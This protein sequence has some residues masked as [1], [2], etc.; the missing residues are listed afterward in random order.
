MNDPLVSVIIRTPNRLAF[1]EA[2]GSFLLQ[3]TG[4]VR[5]RGGRRRIFRWHRRIASRAGARTGAWGAS[6]GTVRDEPGA[7]GAVGPHVLFNERGQQRRATRPRR[8]FER[9]VWLDLVAGW[10]SLHGTVLW[11]TEFIR[12]LGG[13]NEDITGSEDRELFLRA[14]RRGPAVFVPQAALD[15]RTHISRW[16]S[17]EVR[18]HQGRWRKAYVDGLPPEDGSLDSAAHDAYASSNEGR[19]AYGNLRPREA[20]ASYVRAVQASP[21]IITSP[22][23]RR[24]V[25]IGFAKSLA[26]VIGRRG[27]IWARHAKRQLMRALG[28][29]VVEAAGSTT[30]MIPSQH[31]EEPR[32]RGCERPESEQRLVPAAASELSCAG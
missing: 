26:G 14:S 9:T 13:W 32:T 7:I 18:V 5:S 3:K 4:V 8:S 16:R 15:K 6:R 17:P 31:P 30:D 10:M 20:V 28:R 27:V 11:G 1:V 24:R 19:R 21:L 22:L 25:G 2:V 23:Q 12:T 29:D